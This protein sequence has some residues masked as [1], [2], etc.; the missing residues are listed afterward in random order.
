VPG[1]EEGG[2]GAVRDHFGGDPDRCTGLATE[3]RS[4]C[5]VHADYVRGGDN[6]DTA[7]VHVR[8]PAQF[9][10]EQV[11]RTDERHAQLE[12]ADRGECAID[13]QTRRV[14]AAHRVDCDPVHEQDCPSGSGFRV[15]GSAFWFRVRSPFGVLGSVF[16]RTPNQNAEPGTWN[17]EPDPEPGKWLFLIHRAGLAPAVVAAV[18]AHAVRRLRLVAVRTLTEPHRLQCVVRAAFGRSRLRVASFWIRHLVL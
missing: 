12:I 9:G 11:G 3:R 1:A 7:R 8:M 2:G 13:H 15:P 4:G 14:I 16:R 5:L 18:R 17:P 10:A 6:T